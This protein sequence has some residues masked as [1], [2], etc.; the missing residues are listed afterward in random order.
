MQLAIR[1]PSSSRIKCSRAN[2]N[3]QVVQQRKH[4]YLSHEDPQP[5]K[6]WTEAY[7]LSYMNGY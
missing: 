5:T 7:G 4:N 1:I 3:D 2:Q 6:T